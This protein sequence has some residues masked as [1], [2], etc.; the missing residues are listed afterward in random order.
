MWNFEDISFSLL[1]S[2]LGFQRI[3]FFQTIHFIG[4][5]L[6]P[7]KVKSQT[8]LVIGHRSKLMLLDSQCSA[9]SL[10]RTSLCLLLP[11]FP[12]FPC[13][14]RVAKIILINHPFMLPSKEPRLICNSNLNSIPQSCLSLLLLSRE[15]LRHPSSNR[16][17]QPPGAADQCV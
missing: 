10:T 13:G 5:K 7:R 1:F 12:L 4:Q 11:F 17:C 6:R 16:R 3:F 15:V 8:K 9:F 2:A 14:R